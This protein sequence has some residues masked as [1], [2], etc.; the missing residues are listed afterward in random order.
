MTTKKRK[1]KAWIAKNRAKLN[2]KKKKTSLQTTTK[3]K[4]LEAKVRKEFKRQGLSTGDISLNCRLPCS[5][6]IS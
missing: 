3:Y 1:K 4:T 2:R 6:T 5:K